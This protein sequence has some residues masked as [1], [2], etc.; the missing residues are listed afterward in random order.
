MPNIKSAAK[1][2]RQSASNHRENLAA[3]GAVAASR[4]KLIASIEAGN[5]EQ[6]AKDYSDYASKLDKAAKKGAIPSNTADRKK[7]R[8]AQ[9]IAKMA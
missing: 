3:K 8:L 2:V 9:R 7:S 6:V 4:R 1:R 5:K